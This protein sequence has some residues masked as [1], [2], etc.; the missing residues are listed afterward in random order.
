MVSFCHFPACKVHVWRANCSR[1][2]RTYRMEQV[3]WWVEDLCWLFQ[4]PR[5]LK[6]LKFLL[7]SVWWLL[8]LVILPHRFSSLDIV[9][10]CSEVCAGLRPLCGT[11]HCLRIQ[12]LRK[13]FGSYLQLVRHSVDPWQRNL[14][15]LHQRHASV[16]FPNSKHMFQFNS[17][18]F[19][20]SDDCKDIRRLRLG[21]SVLSEIIEDEIVTRE[22][23][24]VNPAGPGLLRANMAGQ[25][26]RLHIAVHRSRVDLDSKW[27]CVCRVVRVAFCTSKLDTALTF[28]TEA[29]SS[30]WI[31]GLLD[32]SFHGGEE[33]VDFHW[34][35]SVEQM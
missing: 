9:D 2:L 8:F 29:F 19:K 30:R 31:F 5:I 12:R 10:L 13:S 35:L 1:I 32:G 7:V 25:M 6:L 18:R 17:G 34:R 11:S 24:P 26:T 4:V 28:T 15:F 21:V 20:K 16:R 3:S 22:L 33:M 14:C 23:L 27:Q